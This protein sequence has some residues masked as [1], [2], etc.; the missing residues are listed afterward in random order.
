M[1]DQPKVT[2]NDIIQADPRVVTLKQEY[3]QLTQKRNALV[4]EISFCESDIIRKMGQYEIVDPS[5]DIDLFAHLKVEF[6]RLASKKHELIL[7]IANGE[8]IMQKKQGEFELLA[9]VIVEEL[10]AKLGV[11]TPP[12]SAPCGESCPEVGCD[13]KN[14]DNQ[15][16]DTCQHV[17]ETQTDVQ[18]PL[19]PDTTP[20]VSEGRVETPE[21]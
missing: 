4:L 6:K 8:G 13:C 14:H 2:I 19:P 20:Y 1:A 12:Q 10:K 15:V 17:D 18:S 5:V 7:E 21:E 9:E 16:C 3:T 11:P